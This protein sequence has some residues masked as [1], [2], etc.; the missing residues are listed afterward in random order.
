VSEAEAGESSQTPMAEGTAGVPEPEATTVI[1]LPTQTAMDG[2]SASETPERASSLGPSC[3]WFAAG[4]VLIA[5][6]IVVLVRW[7]RSR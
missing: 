3:L 4:L 1:P 5:A 2:V 7:R 6:G